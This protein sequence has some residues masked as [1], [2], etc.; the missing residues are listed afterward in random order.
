M[1]TRPKVILREFT[2]W[3]TYRA[4]II[5]VRAVITAQAVLIF[6]LLLERR[7]RHHAELKLRPRLMQVI[8]LNRTVVAGALSASFAHELNQPLGAILSNSETAELLLAE[9]APDLA[10]IQ[11]FVADIR[12]DDLRAGCRP[13]V[14]AGCHTPLGRKTL[15]VAV[16]VFV[17]A[18]SA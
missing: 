17:N 11:D 2:F 9:A 13:A 12:R 3:E 15:I 10:Q 14:Q 1:G 7:R 4:E 8:H 6:W 18:G 5:A 16:A